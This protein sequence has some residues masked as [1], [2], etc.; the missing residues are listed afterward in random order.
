MRIRIL[1]VL[2]A[3]FL[4]SCANF[5][6]AHKFEFGNGFYDFRQEGS[7]YEKAE[8][9]IDEDS[10]L[11]FSRENPHAPI[12]ADPVKTSMFLKKSF[13]LDVM[14][15]AFKYRPRN[16]Y[17]PRQL[18]TD[19]NGNIFMGYRFDRFKVKVSKTPIGIQKSHHHRGITIG[20]FAGLGSTAV[21]PWTTNN[22]ISDEY[23]GLVLDRGIAMMFGVNNLT[24]GVGIGWDYLTDRDKAVWIYQNKPWYG[25]SVGLNIN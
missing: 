10:V 25:L 23:A 9:Y 22:K 18:T 16:I 4:M 13:D 12:V 6:N 17:L 14:T 24:F 21:T 19:F 11:I 3:L 15:I 2:T 5:R 8:V 7:K 20:G 1:L